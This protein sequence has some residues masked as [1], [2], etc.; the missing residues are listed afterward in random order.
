MARTKRAVWRP[1]LSVMVGDPPIIR[2]AKTLCHYCEKPTTAF[3][4]ATLLV[5]GELAF[6]PAVVYLP[7]GHAVATGFDTTKNTY[8]ANVDL[9]TLTG[10]ML[11]A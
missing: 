5:D 3:A 8:V 11:R 4:L 7:C 6:V 9:V 1:A 10:L 2:A